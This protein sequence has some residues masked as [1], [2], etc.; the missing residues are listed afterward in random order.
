[1]A[2]TKGLVPITRSFLAAFYAKHPFDPLHD[3]VEKLFAR[4]SELSEAIDAKRVATEG[5]LR[6]LPTSPRSC[7][8][9]KVS[10][11]KI[12]LSVDL[13][14]SAIA[15]R[16]TSMMGFFRRSGSSLARNVPVLETTWRSVGV[17][18]YLDDLPPHKLDEN[19]WK[20]REQLEEILFLLDDA[21]LPAAVKAGESPAGKA[22]AEAIG[23]WKEEL[24][25]TL[26]LIEKFQE[27]TSERITSMVFTYMPQ[28]FRGT[29]LKQQKERSEARRKQEVA[30]LVSN[31]GTIKQ[32]YALLWQQQMDRRHTLASLG[33]A[34]GIYRTLVTYLVGVPQ[35]LLD[36]VKSINDHNGPMEEQRLSYGPPLYRLTALANRL[37][38]FLALWWSSFDECAE[39]ASDYVGVVSD[40]AAIYSKEIARFLTLLSDV[41]EQSPFLISPEEAMSAEDKSKLEE[42]KE[43]NIA[44]GQSSQVPVTVD[45]VGT[46]VA[47]EFSLTYG[48]DIGFNVE[49]TAEDGTKTGM[50]PYQKVDKHEGSFNAPA[51]GSYTITWDNTYSLLT[52]KTVRYKVGAIPPVETE[53]EL[54]AEEAL[55]HPENASTP[56]AADADAVALVAVLALTPWSDE[57][58]RSGDGVRL[59]MGQAESPLIGQGVDPFT[60]N[61]VDEPVPVYLSVM[62]RKLI[63]VD[64]LKYSYSAYFQVVTSWRDPRVNDTLGVMK[65]MDQFAPDLVADAMSNCKPNV[66]F[67]GFNISQKSECIDGFSQTGL[68]QLKDCKKPCTPAGTRCCDGV[69]LPSLNI[70]NV[71]FFPQDRYFTESIYFFGDIGP[72]MSAVDREVVVEGEFSSPFNFQ[73]FPFDTQDLRFTITVESGNIYLVTSNSGRQQEQASKGLSGG[74]GGGFASDEVTGWRISR[75]GLNCSASSS[76][77]AVSDLANYAQDDPWAQVSSGGGAVDPSRPTTCVFLISIQR[78]SGVYVLSV[79]IPVMLS[80]YLTFSVFFAKPEDLEVRSATCVTLFLAL[81]AVQF[82]IDSQLPRTSAI[83][84]FGYLVITSY[85]F[86]MLSTIESVIV[87]WLAD[88]IEKDVVKAVSKRLRSRK[89]KPPAP[90]SHDTYNTLSVELMKSQLPPPAGV[91]EGEMSVDER[92]DGEAKRSETSGPPAGPS[93]GHGESEKPDDDTK[94]DPSGWPWGCLRHC[95]YRYKSKTEGHEDEANYKLAVVIDAVCFIVFFIAYTV[96]RAPPAVAA[97]PMEV[98]QKGWSYSQYGSAVRDLQFGT[99]PLPEVAPDQ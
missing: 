69:W 90:S 24:Q 33:A 83:T 10:L 37:H 49:Y 38:I 41:F 22:A 8:S 75:V 47:W 36:F 7:R 31:G 93:D 67:A 77:T 66:T 99:V 50:V 25:T 28:D 17:K 55:S 14:A 48:K 88:R 4:L 85:I 26:G 46:L 82:V 98:A 71:I 84:Q 62:L 76:N 92:D 9:S 52:K 45:A 6:P 68:P 19:F 13:V 40:A 79:I 20:N 29:L 2:S 35:I 95:G 51:V 74:G 59:A 78:T 60:S 89:E 27:V 23:K 42:F 63:A 39:N 32:K 80:V 87:F 73:R 43:L 58:G 15:P 96:Q 65:V 30:N 97:T 21:Q 56:T 54:K 1:M 81:A 5:S 16:H 94:C 44:Y 64:E 91:G 34:T 70:P 57:P 12:C 53:E 72:D 61:V 18:H 86:I 11:N 3:D